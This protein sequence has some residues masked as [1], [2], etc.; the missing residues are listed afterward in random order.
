MRRPLT[1]LNVAYPLALVS[2]DA[3]GGAEQVVAQLDAALVA[4]GHRS[5]VVAS[6]G[7]DV[8]GTLVATPR[9]SGVRD[10]AAVTRARAAHRAAMSAALATEPVDVVH[11]HGIDFLEYLPPAGVPVLATLHLPLPWDPSGVFTRSR[12]DTCLQ[13]VSIS[14][15]R[16]GP[17]GGAWLEPIPNG[18][19]VD[20]LRGTR[21]CPRG[22]YLLCLG[23]ICPEKG[24]DQALDA[25]RQAGV[26]LGLGRD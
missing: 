20:R 24:Y 6:E 26:S 1:I 5:I 10:D 19:P 13:C 3:T 2:F 21:P 7:S 8:Q 9:V 11:L 18:I 23:R 12:P 14:Q 22:D 17:G 4:G 16:S 25:A 15:A